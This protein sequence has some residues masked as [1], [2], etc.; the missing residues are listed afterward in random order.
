MKYNGVIQRKL[1][2]LDDQIQKLRRHTKGLSFVEFENDWVIR[3]MSERAL[4]VCSEI[5]IDIA[6]RVIAL[7]N[8]GPA[9]GAGE[10]MEKLQVLGVIS[11]AEPYRSMV[12]LRNLIVHEYEQIDPGILYDII[13]NRLDDFLKFRDEIDRAV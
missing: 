3:S 7:E 13:I 5:M 12:R 1:A 10:A 2:L 6:E 8:A 9:A 4:Q 11:S